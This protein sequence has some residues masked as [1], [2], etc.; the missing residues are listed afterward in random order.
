LAGGSG[1]DYI[2]GGELVP[3]DDSHGV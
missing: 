3:F 1:D 2:D